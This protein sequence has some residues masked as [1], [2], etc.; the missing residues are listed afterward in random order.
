VTAGVHGSH[1]VA[2]HRVSNAG[3]FSEVGEVG[4]LQ[5][6]G[7]DGDTTA[8]CLGDVVTVHAGA[9]F[10]AVDTGVEQVVDHLVGKG[11]GGDLGTGSVGGGNTFDEQLAW[12]QPP[13]VGVGSFGAIDPISN[14][15]DPSVT[16]VGFFGHRLRQLGNVLKLAA[17]V[18][19][20]TLRAGEMVS[21]PDETG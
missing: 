1:A 5:Q 9:V 21:G 19:Q 20:V 10:D 6:G 16:V 14:D 15:L 2:I 17:V 3:L 12:P 13:Q 8:G 7:G 11:V 18:A 4:D